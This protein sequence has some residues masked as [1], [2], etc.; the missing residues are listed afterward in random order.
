MKLLGKTMKMKKHM[1]F[2]S[3][4]SARK[5][6]KCTNIKNNYLGIGNLV[7]GLIIV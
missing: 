1:A 6:L 7:M 5:S 4:K 3:I 2:S